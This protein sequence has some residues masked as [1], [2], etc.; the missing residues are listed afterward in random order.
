VG[1]LVAAMAPGI[2]SLLGSWY[3]GSE[4]ADCRQ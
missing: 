3:S 1:T 4:L 2:E